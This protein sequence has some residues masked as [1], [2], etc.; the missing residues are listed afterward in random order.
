MVAGS[1]HSVILTMDGEIYTWGRNSEGQLGLG[2]RKEQKIPSM[3]LTLNDRH[4]VEV[5]CGSDFTLVLDTS[6]RLWGWGQNEG[7][8]V[9][10]YLNL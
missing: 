3:I 1:N 9:G 10:H 6:A 7:G 5:A 4:I 8:Q 2:S